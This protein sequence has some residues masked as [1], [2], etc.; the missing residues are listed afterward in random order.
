MVS[1][2]YRI[3]KYTYAYKFEDFVADFGGYLVR[4][5]CLNMCE[6]VLS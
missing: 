5:S 3:E 6:I 4:F 1:T 2:Q